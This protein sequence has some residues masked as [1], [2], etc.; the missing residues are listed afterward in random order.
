MLI[1]EQFSFVCKLIAGNWQRETY[2]RWG[3]QPIVFEG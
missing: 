1:F 2:E 3:E